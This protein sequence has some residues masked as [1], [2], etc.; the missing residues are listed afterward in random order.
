MVWALSGGEDIERAFRYG[1]AAGTAAVLRPGTDLA[2][3]DD[4]E[5]ML[6]LLAPA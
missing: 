2:R 6:G 4:I 5:T 3:P 1:M